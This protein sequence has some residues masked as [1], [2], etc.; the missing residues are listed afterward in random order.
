[1]R[2][3]DFRMICYQNDELWRNWVKAE[4]GLFAHRLSF[5][6]DDGLVKLLNSLQKQLFKVNPGGV[7]K[8]ILQSLHKIQT[9][10]RENTTSFA[11]KFKIRIKIK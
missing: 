8:I 4:S 11:S 5:L 3:T 9:H 6:S 1:M 10:L 7:N 2:N